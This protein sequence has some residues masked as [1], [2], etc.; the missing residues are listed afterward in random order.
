MSRLVSVWE[1]RELRLRRTRKQ[2]DHRG[3]DGPGF[4]RGVL[5]DF[6]RRLK[7]AGLTFSHA[8]YDGP[9]ASACARLGLNIEDV[10][11]AIID[12][13]EAV[14]TDPTCDAFAVAAADADTFADY[15]R[16]PDRSRQYARVAALAYCLSRIHRPWQWFALPVERVAGWLPAHRHT[17]GSLIVR[18][19]SDGV[20]RLKRDENGKV[21]WSYPTGDAR[22]AKYRGPD[23][24]TE[25]PL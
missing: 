12:A 9:I 14:A 5:F 6:G 16:R 10:L 17:A 18:L 23:L 19:D 22:E 7:V 15:F 8:W 3:D 24:D 4:D 13:M 1:S 25:I 21:I 2:L 20:I 11:V